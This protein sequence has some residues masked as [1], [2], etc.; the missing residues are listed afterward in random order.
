[1]L[2]Q[3]QKEI[4]ISWIKMMDPSLVGEASR[5]VLFQKLSLEI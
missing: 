2:L 3:G 1:M 5:L 4:Q